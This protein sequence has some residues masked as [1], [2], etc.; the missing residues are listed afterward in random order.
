MDQSVTLCR[1]GS[2]ELINSGPDT[3]YVLGGGC[4]CQ[5]AKGCS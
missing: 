1:L 3:V 2:D 5:P 4:A